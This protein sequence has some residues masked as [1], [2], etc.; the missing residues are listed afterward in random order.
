MS[1]NLKPQSQ[2]TNDYSNAPK[3]DFNA[4]NKQVEADNTPAIISLIVDLGVHT[5]ALNV[6]D[7]NKSEFDVEQDAYDYLERIVEIK[8][9]KDGAAFKVT[10]EGGK[11]VVNGEIYQPKDGQEIAIFA[12]LVDNVVDYGDDIGKKPYRI[13]LNKTWKGEL[14]GFSLKAVPPQNGSKVWTFAGNSMLTKLA[15]ATKNEVVIDGSDNNKLNDVGLLLGSKL[16]VD[17]NK[18][19]NGES[20]YINVS[21][22]SSVPKAIEK[23][24]DVSLVTP[25]GIS[26][27]SATV[28]DLEKAC[29]RGN[30]LKKIKAANNYATSNIRKAVEAYEAKQGVVAKVEAPTVTEFDDDDF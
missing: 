29:L 9:E 20:I 11:F 26:F 18:N 10:P 23:T 5:P 12:D 1:F 3:I 27:D 15:K 14:K 13:G 21:G 2:Q 8:G 4:I 6:S 16:M 28:E 7:K 25:V 19:I 17:V 24:I 22:V 30:I